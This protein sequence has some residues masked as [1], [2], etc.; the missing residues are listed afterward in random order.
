MKTSLRITRANWKPTSPLSLYVDSP[1]RVP[2]AVHL[3]GDG[4]S[5]IEEIKETGM[6]KLEGKIALVTGGSSGIGLATAKRF[7]Q[8]S[9]HVFI[10]GRR[11]TELAE[12]VKEIGKNV[13]AVQ[14]DVSN[15]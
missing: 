2:A 11:K 7:V 15:L 13:T 8:E 14:G 5:F 10:T 9:A 3:R 6:S 1:T 12:A 4:A